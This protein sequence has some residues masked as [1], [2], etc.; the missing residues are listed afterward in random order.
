MRHFALQL[1]V[2]SSLLA[3]SARAET[4]PH[5]GGTLRVSL[6]AT[7]ATLDPADLEKTNA[8][9]ARLIYDTLVTLDERGI[10]RPGLATAWQS[11]PGNQ[12]WQFIFRNGVTFSDG[13]ALTAEGAAAALRVVNPT[14]RISTDN[15]NVIVQLDSADND[16]PAALAAVRNS[17]VRREGG[18]VVGTGPFIV[19]DWQ[20]GK[21]LVAMARNDYFGGRPFLDSVEIDLNGARAPDGS[22]Y[23]LAETATRTAA[24]G[25]RVESSAAS[26]L[27]GLVFARAPGSA[28]EG[29][30]R[31]ALSLSIDRKVLN[32]VLLQ[33]GGEPACSLL[34][35]WM[36]GYEFLFSNENNPPLA[37]QTVSEAKRTST[38]TL[39][40]DAADPVAR[41]MADRIALNAADVGI[42]VVPSTNSAT[43]I[44]LV[45]LNIPSLDPHVALTGLAG[46]IGAAQPK[47]TDS[48]SEE[49]YAAE[50][51]LLQSQRVI[52]LV[53][54]KTTFT[55]DGSVH[56]WTMNRNGDWYL[57]D[58]WLGSEKP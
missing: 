14:W 38:W 46:A 1:L 54:M 36:T 19:S 30:M 45:R 11:D 22:R 32:D 37:R 6:R 16:L 15:D 58:V 51:T 55:L 25:H 26:D 44:R 31:D 13:V 47:F 50:R 2:A 48:S 52:P 40:Y 18:K 33:G 20:A 42:K 35:G 9:L 41:L 39:G 23:Q 5:Y 56:G 34:P 29:R 43:D 49:L 57:A 3:G 8:G 21:K 10:P 12:R 27:L 17:V 7:P 53:H 28:E 4:R 24:N